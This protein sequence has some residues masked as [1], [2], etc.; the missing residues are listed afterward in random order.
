MSLKVLFNG[1]VLVRPGAATKIDASGF[2]NVSL[3]G[4][5]IVGLVGEAD[6]GAPQEIQTFRTAAAAKNYFRSGPI[7]EMA[8]VAFNPSNDPRIG[9]GASALV[10]VKVNP[11]TQATLNVANSGG[12]A[13]PVAPVIANVGV[14]GATTYSYKVVAE[15]GSAIGAGGIS[16][17]AASPV[18][19]TATGNATLDA[20]NY[21]TVTITAVP[22]AINYLVYRTV[23]GATQGLI[24]GGTGL[25][26]NDTGL[27]ADGTTAP[28]VNT[29]A[30]A[31]LLTSKDYGR[32]TNQISGQVTAGSTA[33]G[34]VLIIKFTDGGV[35]NTETSPSLGDT[36]KFTL[37]YTGAAAASVLT[38]T[39]TGL[40]TANTAGEDDLNI[41]WQNFTNL[42]DVI[43]M[44]NAT[45]K[46]TATALVANAG[47]FDPKNLDN[48]PS[49]GVSIKTTAAT[50][51][52]AK[53]D[54]V[55]WVNFNSSYATAS[56]GTG[57]TRPTVQGPTF[58]TGGVR[59][60]TSNTMFTNALA[61]LGGIRVNQVIPLASVDGTYTEVQPS[62]VVSDT[63][64]F[65]SV[66]AATEAHC[67]FYSSTIGK[68]ERQ[69]WVGGHYTKTQYITA[70]NT[71]NSPH[72][73]LFAQQLFLPRSTDGTFI[74]FDEYAT[75]VAAASMRAGAELAEPLTWKYAR[76]FGVKQSTTWTFAADADELLLNGCFL[77]EEVK[78]KGFRWS[79]GLTTYT[80]TDNDAYTQESIVQG[81]K[82]I[83]YEWRTALEDRYI[84]TRGLLSNVGTIV[85]YSHVVLGK[86]R[87]QGQIADSV[88]NGTVISGFRDISASLVGDT[89]QVEG[90]VSPTPGINYILQ[91]IFIVPAQI[92]A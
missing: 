6:G 36:G 12:I 11:S 83:A 32:H 56:M 66:A 78:G 88:I 85:P 20:V 79:K 17:T 39:P 82:N 5:G 72:L 35:V 18:G 61:L 16:T 37:I 54:I 55:A 31:F 23:G 13:N 28:T 46:Y 80:R 47:S 1:A 25:V 22:G 57:D 9:Q 70:A 92:S 41:L 60:V 42:A 33:N 62:G 45:G 69:A 21:N 34:R 59:G 63:Y 3:G 51:Y 75:A 27:A 68:N 67:A 8:Q 84:G 77:I 65:A 52:A 2:A 86:L 24:G 44:I 53:Y 50:L 64:T 48:I 90:T 7:V 15:Y 40:Q 76:A 4:V 30:N 14:A 10:C 74:Y 19:T 73:C 29:T 26:F 38:V 81:W 43:T 91:T 87:D 89:V 58:F 49:P 71:F